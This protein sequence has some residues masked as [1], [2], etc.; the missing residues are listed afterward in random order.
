MRSDNPNEQR[1]QLVSDPEVRERIARR[2]YDLYEQRGGEPG[3][4]EKD[5]LAAEREV[6][7]PEAAPGAQQASTGRVQN[8]ALTTARVAAG[9][10]APERLGRALNCTAMT[11]YRFISSGRLGSWALGSG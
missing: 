7:G 4:G 1:G 6:L 3:H 2:A 11:G 10:A 9:G 8:G 5:W